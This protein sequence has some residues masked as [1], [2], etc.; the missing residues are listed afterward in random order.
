MTLRRSTFVLAG[1]LLAIALAFGMPRSLETPSADAEMS[2]VVQASMTPEVP[3]WTER[4]TPPAKNMPKR[5]RLRCAASIVVDNLTGEILYSRDA[6]ERRPIASLTKLLTAMVFLETGTDMMTTATVTRDDA[7]QSSKSHLRVGETLTLHDFLY[8]ALVSSDNRA[9]RVLA[10]SAG[11]PRD[12]FI[13]LMNVKAREL[14]MDSTYVIE[15]TGLSECN[16]S[17]A[18]DCAILLNL[19]LQNHLIRKV[20]TTSE[21]TVAPLNKRR[22]HRLVNTNRLL[23]YGY[24]FLGS[25]TGY[26][27][28]AGWCIAARGISNDGHDVTVVILGAPTNSK[29]FQ[30][31]R[32][33]L[34]WAYKFPLRPTPES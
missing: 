17:T 1:G 30:S 27:S 22:T 23:R 2:E 10:R 11:V 8:A 28:E 15:P 12:S 31:L 32:N 6:D 7:Y 26:I 34:L 3:T 33:A 18:H 5:P 16:I 29:R 13:V 20:S 9:A 21:L 4:E 24:S 25:K 19:A 14:G